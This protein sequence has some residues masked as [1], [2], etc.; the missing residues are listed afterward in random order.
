[1]LN[2]RTLFHTRWQGVALAAAVAAVAVLAA[3]CGGR[4]AAKQMPQAQMDEYQAMMK[5]RSQKKPG[6][7][8]MVAPAGAPGAAAGAPMVAPPGAATGAPMVAPPGAP[9]GR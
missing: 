9:A 6:G 2:S 1:M 7:A 8:P 4:Q 3:G 5:E